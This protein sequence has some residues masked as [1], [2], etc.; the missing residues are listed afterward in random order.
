MFENLSGKL[1]QIFTNLRKRGKLSA[2]DVDSCA[3]RDTPGF[4]RSGC[5][6]QRG[7]R[8]PCPGKDSR[9]GC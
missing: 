4:A 7:E 2:E 8:F 5:A 6:L 3:A 1:N 9:S